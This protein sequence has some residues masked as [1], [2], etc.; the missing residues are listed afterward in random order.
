MTNPEVRKKISD[1]HKGKHLSEEHKKKLSE[2]VP[3]IK[4]K[5]H[6][7]EAKRKMSNYQKR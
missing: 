3:W 2:Y 6:S 1:A 7:E 4:G 5:T